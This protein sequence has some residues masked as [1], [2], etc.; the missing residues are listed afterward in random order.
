MLDPSTQFYHN[1]DCPARGKLGQG[2]VTIDSQEEHRYRCKVCGVAFAATKSAPYYRLHKASEL[3]VIA[4]TLL[5]HGC[6]PQAIVALFDLD[7]CT[8]AGRQARGDQH[9]QQVHEHIVQQERVDLRHIPRKM[10]LLHSG[11]RLGA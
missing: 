4:L 6:P 7:E 8:M 9:R 11:C 1:P 10:I 5:S 2:N 3:I